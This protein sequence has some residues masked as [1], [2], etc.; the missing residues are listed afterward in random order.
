MKHDTAGD[1][2]SAIKWTRRTTSNISVQL[3]TLGIAV[4]KNTVGRLL[5]Q[6][7]FRLRVNRK[8]IASTKSPDRNQQFLYIA[9]QKER[10]AVQGLPVISVDA[11]KKELIGNFKNPG[12]KWD[13]TPILVKD[14]DFRSEAKA[15]VT[16]Y[17]IYD[18]Q[19][20]RGSVFLGTSHDTPAFAVDAISQWWL[21]EGSKRY[22]AATELFILADGG[23]SNG[24]RCRAWKK[25]I[26]ETICIPLG[27]T[28]TVSHYPPGTSKW[29]PI[30]HRLFSHISRNWAVT[31][32]PGLVV[33][34]RMK[35][36]A[37]SMSVSGSRCRAWKKAIQETICIPL[38]LTVTVSHYPPGTSK[39]N[40]IEHRLFSQISRNWAGEPL[41]DIDKALH[42]IRTT[43]TKP[44]LVVTAQLIADTY[45]K[46]IKIT[47]AEM[48]RLYLLRH[49]TLGRWN[50]TLHPKQIVK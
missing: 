23:G 19:A 7:D 6:M 48:R 17:G 44:G 45:D 1:P 4:S 3:A 27:L 47:D 33:V 20:N 5:K 34:V 18:T 2:M 46:G 10:F 32:R 49:D 43:T 25:A 12:A 26:Q 8:Q 15:L 30:E 41:T 36:R 35:L 40:P 9:Q 50:Y 37:L 13:R 29:N 24:S 28:V 16:P 11:K 38:G 42:F 39:W 31:T 21:Q 14:H 22:P